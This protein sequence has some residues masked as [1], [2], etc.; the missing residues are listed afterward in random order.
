[1]AIVALL[2]AWINYVKVEINTGVIPSHNDSD[3][4]RQRLQELVSKLSDEVLG[5][6]LPDHAT[7]VHEDGV[8]ESVHLVCDVVVVG[9][10][11]HL[12]KLFSRILNVP[13]E[14]ISKGQITMGLRLERSPVVHL[15][16]NVQAVRIGVK[17]LEIV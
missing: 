12:R 5:T 16:G 7:H 17:L 11:D 13:I 10:V 15:L 14:L 9:G 8:L 3:I 2:S 1:M 6:I 4:N